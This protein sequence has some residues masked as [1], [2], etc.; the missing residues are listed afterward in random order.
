VPCGVKHL[1]SPPSAPVNVR[2][3]L[4]RS[5]FA[6]IPECHQKLIKTVKLRA[7]RTVVPLGLVGFKNHRVALSCK[8]VIRESVRL[9]SRQQTCEY[10]DR[11]HRQRLVVL[12]VDLDDGHVVSVDR[13]NEVRVARN[14]HQAET[15]TVQRH[16]I[17]ERSDYRVSHTK[18][19]RFPC[20]TLTT[21]RSAGFGTCVVL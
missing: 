4:R 17:S 5:G 20:L 12:S 11:V 16:D 18:M 14:G 13:E 1:C 3:E 15:I 2:L 6:R 9:K 8:W 19:Y 7:A 21:A 10:L